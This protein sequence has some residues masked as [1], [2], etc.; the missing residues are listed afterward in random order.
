MLVRAAI[1]RTDGVS[2]KIGDLAR[3]CGFNEPG[4][5]ATLYRIAFGDTPS[6]TR[7]RSVDG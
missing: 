3:A 7:R 1:Q 6:A 5:F 4:H 2:A